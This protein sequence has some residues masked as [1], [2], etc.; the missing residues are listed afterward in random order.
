[1]L[2]GPY[3]HPIKS[4]FVFFSYNT[5]M[6]V[7]VLQKIVHGMLLLTY[8]CEWLDHEMTFSLK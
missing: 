4:D 5:I 7:N 1:M 6:F 2:E 8:L 3:Y